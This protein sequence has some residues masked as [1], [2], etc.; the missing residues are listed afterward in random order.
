MGMQFEMDPCMVKFSGL[1]DWQDVYSS[2]RGWFEDR[3]FD[4]DEKKVKFKYSSPLGYDSEITM[5]G[6]RKVDNFYLYSLQ[7]A[8]KIWDFTEVEAIKDGK[9]VKMAKA[10]MEI[11]FDGYI[12]LDYENRWQETA[13]GQKLFNFYWKYIIKG[14]WQLKHWDYLYYEM[15]ALETMIKAKLKMETGVS[16]Y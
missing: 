12:E 6:V 3:K 14:E 4:F 9:R 13:F 2:I 10:R 5:A 11:K 7:V 8:F 15:M 1:Y 16:A